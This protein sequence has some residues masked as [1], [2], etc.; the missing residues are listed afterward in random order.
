VLRPLQLVLL[1]LALAGA[2]QVAAAASLTAASARLGAGTAPVL[3]CDG[4]GFVFR[5]TIDTAGHI[6]SV[7]VSGIDPSCAGGT[8]RLT[9]VNG[10][11]NVGSGSVG[12]PSSGFSGA[13]TLSVSP[14][15]A[16]TAVTAV[17]AV[18]EG[19]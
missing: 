7:A 14:Q 2:F 13:A 8:L 4:D 18:V 10:S 6:T 17:S 16:S 9:L 3:A 15:P 19:P 5:H 11:A 12:L 1:L